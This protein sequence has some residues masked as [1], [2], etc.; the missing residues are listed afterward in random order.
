ML[1]LS[2]VATRTLQ[3][4]SI[5]MA[6]ELLMEK[7]SFPAKL[8]LCLLLI[9]LLAIHFFRNRYQKGLHAVPGPFLNSISSIP[10]IWSVY[11]SQ[12]HSTD[13]ELH[14]RYGRV[15]RLAPRI[16]SVSDVQAINQIYGITT[17]FVKSDFFKLGAFIDEDG[18]YIPDPFSTKDRKI[19]SR[20][21]RGAANAYSLNSIVHMEPYIDK[22]TERLIKLLDGYVESKRPCRLGDTL[23]NYA[24][25]AIFAIT[26]GKD[27]NYLEN[28]DH[29]ELYRSLDISTDYMAIVRTPV[30]CSVSL[31]ISD[32]HSSQFG[33]IP[34]CHKYLLKNRRILEWVVGSATSQLKMLDLAVGEA[35]ASL[36]RPSH[37]DPAT[38]LDLLVKNKQGNPESITD[39]EIYGNALGN[40]SAGSDTTAIALRAVF[41]YLLK[42]C[43]AYKRVCD[44][45]RTNLVLPVRFASADKL[46]YLKSCIKEAMRLHPSVGMMLGREVPKGGAVIGG[47]FI[48]EGVEVG[49]NPMVLHYDPDIFPSPY[50][51]KPERWTESEATSKEHLKLMH[52]AFL[53]FGHGHHTCSGRHISMLE[54]T[55]LVPTL[56]LRYELRFANEGKEYQFKNRWFTTQ[57]G[58]DVLVSKRDE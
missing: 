29:L 15:V 42:N 36:A 21:K 22:V 4:H 34:W 49:I 46:R 6:V 32:L 16:I 54:I 39:D 2:F 47:S 17:K 12:S 3:R 14:R 40:I 13:I 56:L 50:A 18:E 23:K 31:V 53:T 58:L 8:H 26:F 11:R 45:V 10:R 27:F 57:S 37:D 43:D 33:Q 24:M 19:H 35:K 51:F 48:E 9:G 1:R 52:G 20:L 44:E 30:I 41:Y 7:L 5:N 28:G 55:K 38:F 25:D